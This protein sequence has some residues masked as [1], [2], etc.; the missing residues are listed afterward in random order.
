[1]HFLIL[2]LGQ[3]LGVMKFETCKVQTKTCSEASEVLQSAWEKTENLGKHVLSK[4]LIH[5]ALVL[6]N[7]SAY[8]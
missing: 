5:K 1:M 6:L 7:G 4:G 2:R 3:V 8:V